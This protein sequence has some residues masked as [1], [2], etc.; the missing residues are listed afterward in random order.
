ME[1]YTDNVSLQVCLFLSCLLHVEV[2]GPGINPV[3]QRWIKPLQRQGWVLNPLCHKGALRYK[4]ISL[5]LDQRIIK[6]VRERLR[7]DTNIILCPCVKQSW[8][9][10]EKKLFGWGTTGFHNI[11][12]EPIK[13]LKRSTTCFKTFI[14]KM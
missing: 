2:P 6:V 8:D 11:G 10:R 3:P 13:Q 5:S 12:R 4:D 7:I 14:S 1:I 9:Y